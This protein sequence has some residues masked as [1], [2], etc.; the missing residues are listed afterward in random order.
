MVPAVAADFTLDATLLVGAFEPW[1]RELGHEQVVRSQRDEP[2]S[3][4]PPAALQ[5]FL[6]R[7]LQVVEPDL[8]KYAAEPFERLHVQ[9]KERLLGLDQRRLAER[10]ARE[11]RAHH[12]QMHLHRHAAEHDQ[13]LAPIDLR[14]HARGVDLRDEHLVDRPPQLALAQPDVLTDSDLGDIGTVLI[15]E[16]PPDPLGG[17]PLLGR[18]V[19]I[20]QQ[21]LVDQRPIRPQLRRRPAHRRTLRRRHRRRQRLLHR[22][23]MNPMP[24]RQTTDREALPITVSSD[25]LELLHPGSHSLWRLPLELDETRTVGRRSDGG[26]AS[27][28]HRSG[29]S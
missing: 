8:L 17:M 7:R 10:R 24:D 25:L 21:P 9:L 27:S 5:H 1:G 29:A 11:R 23:A 20:R 26:G 2:V 28:D 19:A 13:R 4:D 15:N 22:P 12:E 18:R 6:H 14:L 3:L 16:A